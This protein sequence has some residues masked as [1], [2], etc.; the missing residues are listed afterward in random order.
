[1]AHIDPIVVREELRRLERHAEAMTAGAHAAKALLWFQEYA[2]ER[3]IGNVLTVQASLIAGSTPG[4]EAAKSFIAH[5]A[6]AFARQ[7]LDA[8]IAEAQQRFDHAERAR[9]AS[10]RDLTPEGKPSQQPKGET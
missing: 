3:D 4:V 6:K 5:A 10:K 8:A 7:V 2:A 9:R 1:M